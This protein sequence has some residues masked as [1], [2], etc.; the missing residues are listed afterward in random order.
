MAS[1]L[2]RKR[3][4]SAIAHQTHDATVNRQPADLWLHA[5]EVDE[6]DPWPH[7]LP[8]SAPSRRG[9]ACIEEFQTLCAV[10]NNQVIKRLKPGQ[11]GTRGLYRRFGPA[12]VCVRYRE[13]ESGNTRFTTVELVVDQRPARRQLLV[14]VKIRY[15]DLTMR[16]HALALGA[17][18]DEA[19]RTWRMPRRAAIQLGLLTNRPKPPK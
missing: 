15:D 10:D 19:E 1:E 2:R 4:P 13:N 16:R 9:Q 14:R 17:Q 8:P 11:A 18:W 5:P 12:L 6:R 3:R 7:S